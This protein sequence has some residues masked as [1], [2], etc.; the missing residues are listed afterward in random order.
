MAAW[1]EASCG[2]RLGAGHERTLRAVQSVLVAVVVEG[3][4][5][6][7]EEVGVA[8]LHVLRVVEGAGSLAVTG[9]G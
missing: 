6:L 1:V 5:C 8:D 4:L 7:L 3:R 9:L 2:R